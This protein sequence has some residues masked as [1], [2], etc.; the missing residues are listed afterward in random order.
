MLLQKRRAVSNII[1]MRDM[2]LLVCSFLVIQGHVLS[3]DGADLRI[4]VA[5]QPVF[6]HRVC[7]NPSKNKSE[8]DNPEEAP[9]N[10]CG[11][12]LFADASVMLSHV[13]HFLITTAALVASPCILAAATLALTETFLLAFINICSK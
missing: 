13:Q 8:E 5:P 11:S 6:V 3:H 7:S 1:R 9:A 2:M 4:H 10:S 12:S